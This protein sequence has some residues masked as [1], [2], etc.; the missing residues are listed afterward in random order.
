[1][2]KAEDT[3]VQ[4]A[5][6][7]KGR[8]VG[9]S[10]YERSVAALRSAWRPVPPPPPRLDPDLSSLPATA[11]VAE[12]LRYSLFAIERSVSP[13]GGLRA[14][15]KLNVLVALVLAVPAALVIPVVTW[16]LHGFTTWSQYLAKMATNFVVVGG[17]AL[18]LVLL[19]VIIGRIVEWELR[20]R[21]RARVDRRLSGRSGRPSR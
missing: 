8:M 13:D 3:D 11:R 12:V 2:A 15:L 20:R 7:L 9:G 10:L 5:E 19:F 4:S 1:M 18:I 21:A 17:C 16:L 6:A 14:W